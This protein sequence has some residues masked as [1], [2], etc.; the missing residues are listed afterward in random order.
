M[1]SFWIWKSWRRAEW[2]TTIKSRRVWNSCG[3]ATPCRHQ[4]NNTNHPQEQSRTAQRTSTSFKESRDMGQ[5]S[6]KWIPFFLQDGMLHA[7]QEMRNRQFLQP[8]NHPF[9]PPFLSMESYIWG[10]SWISWGVLNNMSSPHVI[11]GQGRMWS[12]WMV[13]SWTFLELDIE[14]YLATVLLMCLS[15]T[16]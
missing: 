10:I 4:T 7:K 14:R 16:S 1:H 15:H 5:S 2:L 3:R 13:L 6:Q 9:P 12:S 8:W 11:Q